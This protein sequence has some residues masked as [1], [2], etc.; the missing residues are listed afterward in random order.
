MTLSLLLAPNVL[1]AIMTEFESIVLDH[2][3]YL[4]GALHAL[5]EDMREVKMR[6]DNLIE[7]NAKRLEGIE[8]RRR[9]PLLSAAWGKT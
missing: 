3:V 5:C 2:L 7:A 1:E 6:L 4:R 8:R 9:P